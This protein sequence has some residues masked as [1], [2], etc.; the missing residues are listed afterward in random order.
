MRHSS[1][2]EDFWIFVNPV[3]CLLIESVVWISILVLGVY[4]IE[5]LIINGS[6]F[7]FFSD[8]ENSFKANFTRMVYFD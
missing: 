1:L 2:F 6:L 4:F 3:G 5:Y 8:F 7:V